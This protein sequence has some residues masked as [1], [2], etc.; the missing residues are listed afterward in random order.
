MFQINFWKIA[1]CSSLQVSFLFEI[2]LKNQLIRR[3]NICIISL[4]NDIAYVGQLIDLKC[5]NK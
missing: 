1:E 4:G 2:M 3:V 5:I